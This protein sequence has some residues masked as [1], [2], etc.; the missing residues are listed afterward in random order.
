MERQRVLNLG[1]VTEHEK[2]CRNTNSFWGLETAPFVY[3]S[4]RWGVESSRE[5]TPDSN[6]GS[7]YQLPP[8]TAL[9]ASVRRVHKGKKKR[10]LSPISRSSSPPLLPVRKQPALPYGGIIGAE[11]R[12]SKRQAAR[13]GI[14]YSVGSW[15]PNQ[16]GLSTDPLLLS[17]KRPKSPTPLEYVTNDEPM[18]EVEP[19]WSEW[20]ANPYL[21]RL[22]K[23]SAEVDLGKPPS[24]EEEARVRFGIGWSSEEERA[25]ANAREEEEANEIKGLLRTHE[26]K[27][28][29]R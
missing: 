3:T 22:G 5:G 17:P 9:S 29:R 7:S 4:S 1:F 24:D 12:C 15:S 25:E 21:N 14:L 26:R 13:K 2:L 6:T 10:A 27:P 19:D 18:K 16:Q 28:P 20:V 8:T 11:R 23:W